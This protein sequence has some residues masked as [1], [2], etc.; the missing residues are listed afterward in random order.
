M[1]VLMA[2]VLAEQANGSNNNRI[3]VPVSLL[4]DSIQF[5]KYIGRASHTNEF[6]SHK[7][8]IHEYS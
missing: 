2:N 6:C 7:C 4:G 1:V 3:S 5:F 8:V